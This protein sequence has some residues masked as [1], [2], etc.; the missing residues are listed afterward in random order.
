MMP[1]SHKPPDVSGVDDMCA[2][3]RAERKA[4]IA[5]AQECGFLNALS[6]LPRLYGNAEYTLRDVEN[7]TREQYQTY[8]RADGELLI[9]FATEHKLNNKELAEIMRSIEYSVT[10]VPTVVDI[11]ESNFVT[12]QDDK[13]PLITAREAEQETKNGLSHRIAEHLDLE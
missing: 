1:E 11:F 12:S 7:A 9:K 4:N 6:D 5:I 10:E 13:R 3:L 8:G 2:K